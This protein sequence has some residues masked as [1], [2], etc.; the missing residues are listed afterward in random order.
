[1]DQVED[2][3]I[4]VAGWHVVRLFNRGVDAEVLTDAIEILRLV[5][6]NTED[7]EVDRKGREKERRVK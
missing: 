3:L 4:K 7:I 5:L 6:L 1:M 2:E